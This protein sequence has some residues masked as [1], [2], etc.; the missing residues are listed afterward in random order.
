MGARIKIT[1]GQAAMLYGMG[2]MRGRPITGEALALRATRLLD[3]G[4]IDPSNTAA[5]QLHRAKKMF[6]SLDI[7]LPFEFRK[8]IGYAWLPKELPHD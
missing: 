7:P 4:Q 8:Y 2:L 3:G 5:V 6:N 1:A